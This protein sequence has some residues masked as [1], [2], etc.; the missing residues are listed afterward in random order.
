M[1][2]PPGASLCAVAVCFVFPAGSMT[3]VNRTRISLN[4]FDFDIKQNISVQLS[5]NKS[6]IKTVGR[7][8][9]IAAILKNKTLQNKLKIHYKVV[10]K[11]K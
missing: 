3:T 5:Q 1:N 7:L 4:T 10:E 8:T 9:R 2:C 11:Q 6:A